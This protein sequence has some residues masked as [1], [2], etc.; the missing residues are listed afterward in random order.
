MS[1][2]NE[3][4]ARENDVSNDMQTSVAKAQALRDTAT[5]CFRYALRSW[6]SEG[7]RIHDISNVILKWRGDNNEEVTVRPQIPAPTD[8]GDAA[9]DTKARGTARKHL[10][11]TAGFWFKASRKEQENGNLAHALLNMEN[12]YNH[13]ENALYAAHNSATAKEPDAGSEAIPTIDL[14]KSSW[15][16]IKQAARE[17]KWMPPEY[18]TPDWVS[19][20]CSFLRGETQPPPGQSDVK[21][22]AAALREIEEIGW[23]KG[24]AEAHSAAV[25]MQ[26]IAREALATAPPLESAQEEK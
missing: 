6:L 1:D 23:G 2:K 4:S 10:V 5:A 7:Q 3:K 11:E 16:A 21:G 22:F 15:E 14:D 18:M 8:S 24:E 26:E 20:V 17:S 19:D 9:S 12:A 13:V 25:A